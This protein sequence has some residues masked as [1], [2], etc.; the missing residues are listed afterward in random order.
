[1]ASRSFVQWRA[2]PGRHE[3]RPLH[4]V[5]VDGGRDGSWGEWWAEGI[6]NVTTSAAARPVWCDHTCFLD[7]CGSYLPLFHMPHDTAI[8]RG[9]DQAPLQP[10]PD[11]NTKNDLAETKSGKNRLGLAATGA[12]FFHFRPICCNFHIFGNFCACTLSLLLVVERWL[13]PWPVANWTGNGVRR[14]GWC[15]A[16]RTT[17]ARDRVRQVP[18]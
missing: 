17:D 2:P 16:A 1:M 12:Q 7:L 11:S 14:Q 13:H 10:A 5:W 18:G 4:G 3:P 6:K 15:R 8:F 9:R